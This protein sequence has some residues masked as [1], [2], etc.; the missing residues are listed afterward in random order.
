MLGSFKD[1]RN[2][3]AIFIL[4]SLIIVS[5]VWLLFKRI[6]G[7][8]SS[9]AYQFDV[10][11]SSFVIGLTV[12]WLTAHKLGKFRG[13]VRFLLCLAVMIIIVLLGMFPSLIDFDRT[14]AIMLV[15]YCFVAGVMLL[16]FAVVRKLCKNRYRPKA[17][18][19][20]LALCLPV[21]GIIALVG[22]IIVAMIIVQDVP[23]LQIIPLIFIYG[24]II[25]LLLY[26]INLPFMIV[27]FMSPFYRERFCACL[28]LKPKKLINELENIQL[29]NH[30]NSDP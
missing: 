18:M 24:L 22:Y 15:M 11:F 28:K 9:S 3:R 4:I 26:I 21:C 13:F 6:V 25:G 17:F 5:F 2:Y 16:G 10:L 14:I 20:W 7:M 1:N 19:L 27:A 29:N 23:P 30:K 12:L 8:P